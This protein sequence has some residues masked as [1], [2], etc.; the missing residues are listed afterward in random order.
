MYGSFAQRPDIIDG[1]FANDAC[2]FRGAMHL[3]PREVDKLMIFTAG[4]LARKT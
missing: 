1:C 3:T 2:Y 4:E